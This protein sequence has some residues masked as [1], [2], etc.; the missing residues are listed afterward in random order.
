MSNGALAWGSGGGGVGGGDLLSANNLSDLADPATA[1]TN[2][3]LGN[4]ENTAL[5]TWTGTSNI[6]KVGTIGTG[7]WQGTAIGD[8]YVSSGLDW[9]TAYGWGDHAGEGYLTTVGSQDFDALQNVLA[10]TEF[11]DDIL[12]YNATGWDSLSHGTDGQMLQYTAVSGLGWVNPGS[13]DFADG[14]ESGGAN[15]TLGNT[16]AF[17]LA[18]LTNN[19]ERLQIAQDGSVDINASGD[20]ALELNQGG[21]GRLFRGQSDNNNTDLEVYGYNSDSILRLT[22]GNDNHEAIIKFGTEG[23]ANEG[24]AFIGQNSG[25]NYRLDI[26]SGVDIGYHTDGEGS[27]V[28][29]IL[30]DGSVGIGTVSPDYTLDVA[31]DVGI[32]DYIYHNDDT[33]TYTQFTPDRWQV[34]TGGRSMIDAQYS[35]SELTINEGGTQTDF[36]VEG[37]NEQNLLFTDGSTDRVGIGTS[38]PGA[39]LHVLA[40]AA[41]NPNMMIEQTVAGSVQLNLKNITREWRIESDDAP[42]VFRIRDVTAGSDR[43]TID[44]SGSIGIGTTSP[45]AKLDVEV[46]VATGGAATIG[47]SGNTAAGDYAIAMGYNTTASADYSFAAGHQAT[48]GGISSVSMGGTTIASALHSTAMGHRGKADSAYS[49]AWGGDHCLGSATSC[50]V[51]NSGQF[52]IFGELCVATESGDCSA[53]GDGNAQK[54]NG[55]TSWSSWSDARLKDYELLNDSALSSLG[56]LSPIK[57]TYN[58]FAHENFGFDNETVMY[59]FTAQNVQKVFPEMVSEDSNGYLMYNPSGFEAILTKA[60]QELKAENDDLEV[61]LNATEQALCELGRLEFCK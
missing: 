35:A 12:F 38:S 22:T 59:G 43:V 54:Q 11:D 6:T 39:L 37:G 40:D 58:D 13:A 51:D 42:D 41:V 8:T 53:L 7:I 23:A 46:S 50:D 49:F 18:F 3:V 2:L 19:Q 16:D 29:T 25:D 15:R 55:G 10:M 32:D 33:N 5:S 60:I 9:N 14:G 48:A 36:R 52:A 45:S 17:G 4:V 24:W 1:R 30:Q 34:F 61:R 47:S 26:A 20:F 28:L 27:P 44:N 21:T 31:G 57:Y 56:T